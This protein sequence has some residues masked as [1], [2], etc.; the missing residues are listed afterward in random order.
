IESQSNVPQG[1]RDSYEIANSEFSELL[2]ELSKINDDVKAFEDEME[3]LG[4]PW[5]PGRMPK[6][7]N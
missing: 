1:F 3:S 2:Q 5:T 6:W 4:A 7:N